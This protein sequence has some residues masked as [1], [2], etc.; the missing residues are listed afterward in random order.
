M[1]PVSGWWER[2]QKQDRLK[3]G[4]GE[5]HH[6]HNSGTTCQQKRQP[7]QAVVMEDFMEN[8]MKKAS[9][10][11][12][13]WL[14]SSLGLSGPLPG[15]F[16]FRRKRN[17]A[18]VKGSGLGSV[19][20]S[21]L[22]NIKNTKLKLLLITNIAVCIWSEG[23]TKEQNVPGWPQRGGRSSACTLSPSLPGSSQWACVSETGSKGQKK[24]LLLTQSFFSF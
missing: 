23:K 15:S 17:M 6:Q 20:V 2:S 16:M 8:R 4:E 14:K 19:T 24:V 9:Y 18:A 13:S 10:F 3:A 5:V 22:W 12:Q 1:L 11:W 7:V 21:G